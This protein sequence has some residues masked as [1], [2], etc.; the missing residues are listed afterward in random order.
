LAEYEEVNDPLEPMNRE[1]FDLNMALDRAIMKPVAVFYQDNLPQ[2][3]RTSVHNF[4]NNMR[5]PVIFAND[6][7]QGH[8]HQAADT[9]GRFMINSTWGV[10]GL[11]DV[12][13]DTNGPKYHPNDFAQTFAAWG[14]PDGP[15]LMLPLYGPSSPR[16]VAGKTAAWFADPGDYLYGMAPAAFSDSRTGVDMV[17]SRARM[18]DP[19]DDVERNSIDFYA[20]VRSL[21]RQQRAADLAKAQ[22]AAENDE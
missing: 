22:M 18:I 2:G 13:A 10:L 16:D 19:L 6:L 5:S 15:F 4:L 21:Y 12:V 3:V 20:A 7:L 14:L 11:F 9:L 8:P 1:I 17:D